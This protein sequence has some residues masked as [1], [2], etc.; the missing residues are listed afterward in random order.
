MVLTVGRLESILSKIK[1]KETLIA[2]AD[3]S[4]HPKLVS[5]TELKEMLQFGI[6]IDVQ[7]ALVLGE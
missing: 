1:D 6:K 4:G 2:R 3:N 5:K 7:Y